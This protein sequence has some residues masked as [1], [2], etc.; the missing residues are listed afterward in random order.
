MSEVQQDKA[1]TVAEYD[2][3]LATKYEIRNNLQTEISSLE[4]SLSGAQ[5]AIATA[6][7]QVRVEGQGQGQGWWG[8]CGWGRAVGLAGGCEGPG[9]GGGGGIWAVPCRAELC[10]A[11]RRCSV[12]RCA[13]LSCAVPCRAVLSCAVLC[14]AVLCC[15]ALQCAVLF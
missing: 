4:S 14:C 12:R 13:V 15:C 7:Y 9:G 8:L 2:K 11:V 3:I 10:C 6:E 5:S 1:D